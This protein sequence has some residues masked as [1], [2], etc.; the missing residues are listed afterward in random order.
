M[1]PSIPKLPGHGVAVVGEGA[2]F[3]TCAGS[4]YVVAGSC[5]LDDSSSMR[6]VS[7]LTNENATFMDEGIY[8]YYNAF[9]SMCRVP[10]HDDLIIAAD[11]NQTVSLFEV[12][13]LKM[14]RSIMVAGLPVRGC[15]AIYLNGKTFVYVLIKNKFFLLYLFFSCLSLIFFF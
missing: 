13:T 14:K 3:I 7:N 2:S 12:P 5:V 6:I 8:H 9:T 4:Q 11:E 10:Q 15:D 1:H